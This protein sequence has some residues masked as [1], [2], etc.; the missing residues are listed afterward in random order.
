MDRFDRAL[1]GKI[2]FFAAGPLGPRSRVGVSC[3]RGVFLGV[4][5]DLGAVSVWVS[6]CRIAVHFAGGFSSPSRN[7]IGDEWRNRRLL[8]ICSPR[9]FAKFCCI[10]GFLEILG[11][12]VNAI[13]TI[14]FFP[15]GYEKPVSMWRFPCFPWTPCCRL[16]L[17]S[18]Q[19]VH[20]DAWLSFGN[21]FVLVPVIM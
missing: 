2:G 11:V 21:D 8:V 1:L 14:F 15:S 10:Y 13:G 20:T 9:I 12:G 6:W 7:T 19:I 4:F 17:S 3:D 18:C 16:L 5:R